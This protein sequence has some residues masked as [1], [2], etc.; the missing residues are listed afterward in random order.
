MFK[1]ERSTVG[2]AIGANIWLSKLK[3]QTVLCLAGSSQIVTET[4]KDVSGVVHLV[5]CFMLLVLVFFFRFP[6]SFVVFLRAVQIL[7]PLALFESAAGFFRT[8]NACDNEF[9][10]HLTSFL[11][12]I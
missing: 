5:R 7:Q 11:D 4:T 8:S 1:N 9:S 12:S 10:W 6:D 3:E 2:I